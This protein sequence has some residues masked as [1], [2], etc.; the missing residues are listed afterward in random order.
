MCN[1]LVIG[2]DSSVH[3]CR[4]FQFLLPSRKDKRC[5]V[6]WRC[7]IIPKKR[8]PYAQENFCLFRPCFSAEIDATC[9][10]FDFGTALH[11][12]ASN[13]CLSAVKCLLELRAN[14]AFRVSCLPSHPRIPI[15]VPVIR[16]ALRSRT[17]FLH[18]QTSQSY[19]WFSFFSFSSCSFACLI[20][21]KRK[22]LD[23]Q[24]AAWS[25][26]TPWFIPHWGLVP[27]YGST[28]SARWN[29]YTS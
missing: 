18:L 26:T 4:I 15:P 5:A 25:D 19:S 16:S 7:K 24:D 2:S 14:P 27:R 20:N 11:I 21:C 12:A 1:Q 29:N 22:S 9:S 13:L 8:N 6:G 10:D 3:C 17:C 28:D 23:V